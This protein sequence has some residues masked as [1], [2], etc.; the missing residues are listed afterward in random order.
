MVIVRALEMTVIAELPKGI[1]EHR[2]VEME[3]YYFAHCFKVH[4]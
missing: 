3:Y 1:S 4:Q 2:C